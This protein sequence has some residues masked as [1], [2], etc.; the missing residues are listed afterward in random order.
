M[1]GT[2]TKMYE[3]DAL[4]DYYGMYYFKQV[5]NLQDR[6]EQLIL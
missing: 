2:T 6:E 4:K 1:F 3:N 5:H